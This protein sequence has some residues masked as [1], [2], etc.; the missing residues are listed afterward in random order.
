MTVDLVHPGLMSSRLALMVQ[1]AVSGGQLLD[2]CPPFEDGRVAP[3]GGASDHYQL[4]YI[5]A[6]FDAPKPVTIGGPWRMWDLLDPAHDPVE[7][8][9]LLADEYWPILNPPLHETLLAIFDGLAVPAPSD[10]ENHGEDFAD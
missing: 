9:T 5:R 8:L 10:G 2:L 7:F 6:R 4:A 3:E 1:S